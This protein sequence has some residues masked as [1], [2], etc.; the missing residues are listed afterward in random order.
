MKYILFGGIG[1]L[2]NT[3][4]LQFNA[5]NEAFK[6]YDID[7]QWE[8]QKYKEMLKDPGGIKRINEFAESHSSLPS[9]VSAEQVH[10]KKT[11][12]FINALQNKPLNLRSGVTDIFDKSQNSGFAK[13]FAT[14]TYKPVVSAILDAC[15]VQAR[16]FSLITNRDLVE[17]SKPSPEVYEL[18]MQEL[19]M[20]PED[21]IAIEDSSS[22]VQSAVAAGIKCIAF[23]NEFTQNQNFEQA[24]EV[25]S[26]L[27]ES[28]LLSNATL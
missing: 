15:N 14:T 17:N 12:L 13:V 1:T 3:S 2:V 5:F 18:C 9:G 28:A 26:D 11:E 7:W 27:S 16:D 10:A 20:R 8:E 6:F 25:V 21:C 24:S 22:G 19:K 4:R 23:P